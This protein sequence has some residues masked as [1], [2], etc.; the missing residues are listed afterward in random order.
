MLWMK[1]LRLMDSLLIDE[2]K[3]GGWMGLRGIHRVFQNL[4]LALHQTCFP[5]GAPT[6]PSPGDKVR[7]ITEAV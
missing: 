7:A 5:P 3:E 1:T 4:K 6:F 2:A